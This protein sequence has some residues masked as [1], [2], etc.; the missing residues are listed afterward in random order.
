M[1]I[2]RYGAG[3]GVLDGLLYAVGGF[4]GLEVQKSVEVY[5][6][7]SGVWTTLPD[8]NC[9]RQ[10]PGVVALDGLLYVI[11]GNDIENIYYSVEFY[12]PI[13]NTW[14]MK[15]S[16]MNV[17]RYLASVVTIVKSPNFKTY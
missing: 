16:S 14:F 6:P 8:M 7:S 17:T 13:S 2:H 15:E 9:P 11:G 10:N 3:V 1:C 5:R 4:N 12:D